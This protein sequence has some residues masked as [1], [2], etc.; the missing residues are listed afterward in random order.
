MIH[1]DKL[2]YGLWWDSCILGKGTNCSISSEFRG[3]VRNWLFAK[4]SK[5]LIKLSENERSQLVFKTCR[6][7]MEHLPDK[8]LKHPIQFASFVR[9]QLPQYLFTCFKATQLKYGLS[10]QTYALYC[11]C[12][13]SRLLAKLFCSHGQRCKSVTVLKLKAIELLTTPLK[14][15]GFFAILLIN[16]GLRIQQ[17]KGYLTVSRRKLWNHRGPG[18]S[19]LLLP[20]FGMANM[21]NRNWGNVPSQRSYKMILISVQD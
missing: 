11:S 9:R 1:T 7:S 12:R 18:V 17:N 14:W 5:I 6:S 10:Q 4:G 15:F 3:R 19:L 20:Y 13:I 16:G 21:T 2:S 8:N